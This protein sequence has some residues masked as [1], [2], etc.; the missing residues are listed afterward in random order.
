MQAVFEVQGALP[1]DGVWEE[2]AVERGV[3][4]QKAVKLEDLGGGHDLVEPDLTRRKFG[5]VTKGQ[6]VVGIRLAVH[7]ALENHDST[8]RPPPE[9]GARAIRLPVEISAHSARETEV[10]TMSSTDDRR[11]EVLRAIVADYVSTQ[12]PVGSKALVER[13]NLGVSSAT[14]RNDMAF[15]EAEG[16]IAQPHTSSGRV[17]TDKGYREFVDRIADVKPL[18]GPERRAILEFLESGVDLDDV[19]RRG[20]RLLAQLTRQV[21]VVQYPTLSASSVRH[22]EVV[23][24]TPARLLLVLITDSGRVD[25]RIVELGDVLVDEDLSRL[26]ALLGGALEGKRLAAASIAVSELAD[27]APD[28]LRDAVVRSATILVETLVEHPEERLVLGGTANLTRNASDFSG[29]AGF[30]G[31]LRAVLEALEEQVVVLKLLASTQ[32]AGMVTVRIGEETQVEQ[33]RG[34]SVISTGYGAAGTVFGGVG[35]LGP[36][37]MDYPGTIASVAAVARYIGEVLSER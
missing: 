8:V 36:T 21:A 30:P 11:F 10:A 19:L 31:S 1:L 4:R 6:S 24:L 12:D 18:S 9:T 16:Y 26:R 27:E 2:I 3:L 22:L 13:H 5:P 17:P 34:T 14:V 20:V 7:H 37:R 29:L 35:V 28:D 33:M 15:L 25:Q 23:A 32:N